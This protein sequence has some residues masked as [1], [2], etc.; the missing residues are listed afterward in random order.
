MQ[1][2]MKMIFG[3]ESESAAGDGSPQIGGSHDIIAS[4]YECGGD[5]FWRQPR[6]SL[7]PIVF[8]NST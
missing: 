6:V 8:N 5:S 3:D 7:T 1:L 4:F 2:E